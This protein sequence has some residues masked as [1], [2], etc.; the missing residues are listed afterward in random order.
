MSYLDVYET[1]NNYMHYYNNIFRHT[2][3]DDISPQ[4]SIKLYKKENLNQKN[5]LLKLEKL[6]IMKLNLLFL[7]Y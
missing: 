4:I 7:H 5:L 3:L 2:S 1:I 6:R